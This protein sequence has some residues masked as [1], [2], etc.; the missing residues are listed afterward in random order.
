MKPIDSPFGKIIV[1][2][3]IPEGTIYLLPPVTLNRYLNLQTGEVKEYFSFNPAAA[4]IITNV[5]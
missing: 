4:G 2:E 5:K 3:G 1:S